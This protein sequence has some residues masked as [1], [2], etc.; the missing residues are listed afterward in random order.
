MISDQMGHLN[1]DGPEIPH[2]KA[3]KRKSGQAWDA[4]WGTASALARC[5]SLNPSTLGVGLRVSWLEGR[6]R[7]AAAGPLP[8]PRP[9]CGCRQLLPPSPAGHCPEP[10]DMPPRRPVSQGLLTDLPSDTT[11]TSGP[12]EEALRKWVLTPL[13]LPPGGEACRCLR[14]A[15]KEQ[16]QATRREGDGASV[17][18]SG[19]TGHGG[20]ESAGPW[21][22]PQAWAT[23]AWWGGHGAT[24]C[25]AA[26]A[27]DSLEGADE[28][29][30]P[31]SSARARRLQPP[32]PVWRGRGGELG[33]A[34]PPRGRA[35]RGLPAG[36]PLRGSRPRA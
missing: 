8:A 28:R 10:E 20:G 31:P 7:A 13:V 35:G 4:T 2:F 9:A 6:V 18:R 16:P 30:G 3:E 22:G 15:R 14:D 32:V 1:K 24:A 5:L 33:G 27:W 26:E 25:P 36:L 17:Q 21:T 19:E 23:L 34:W 29:C 11:L 12:Q